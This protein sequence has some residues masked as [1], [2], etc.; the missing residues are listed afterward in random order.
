VFDIRETPGCIE[1]TNTPRGFISVPV[2][3]PFDYIHYL[4]LTGDEKEF[5]VSV[6]VCCTVV[7]PSFTGEYTTSKCHNK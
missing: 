6:K 2:N 4:S 5:S 7:M 3:D 1:L